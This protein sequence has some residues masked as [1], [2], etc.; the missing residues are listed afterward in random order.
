MQTLRDERRGARGEVMN[1]VQADPAA[2][3]AKEIAD[4]FWNMPIR[5]ADGCEIS[6]KRFAR[7]IIRE[8][9]AEQTAE[10]KRLNK[11]IDQMHAAGLGPDWTDKAV[12]ERDEEIERLRAIV[13]KLRNAKLAQERW[14]MSEDVVTLNGKPVGGTI[15]KHRREF[16]RWWPAVKR[17]LLGEAAEA[18]GG[19]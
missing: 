8:A 2:V 7:D 17:E 3:A 19:K 9:Y 4:A 14:E 6:A 12:R 1:N 5:R 10:L 15:T 16:D 11:Q 18:A 13:D